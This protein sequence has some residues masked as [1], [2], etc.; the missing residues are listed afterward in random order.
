MKQLILVF[1]MFIAACAVTPAQAQTTPAGTEVSKSDFAAKVNQLNLLI[2]SH[3]MDVAK[4][5]W[6]EVHDMMKAEFAYFKTKYKYAKETNNTLD[7]ARYA[8]WHKNQFEKYTE[9]MH[10]KEDMVA[11]RAKL[12][13][14]LNDFGTNML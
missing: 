5:K 3:N 8:D 4:A 13:G 6:N 1:G 11:N 9:I 2:G 7:L 14:K 10:L 12:I